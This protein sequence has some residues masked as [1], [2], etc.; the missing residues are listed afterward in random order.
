M[1]TDREKDFLI[2]LLNNPNDIIKLKT[3]IVLAQ[4]CTGGLA[5]IKQKA[6]LTPEPFERILLHIQ[7]E[8]L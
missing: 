8:L 3:A 7:S 6:A 1:A 5:F 4:C 2:N